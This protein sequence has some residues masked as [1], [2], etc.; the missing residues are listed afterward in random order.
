MSLR[1]GRRSSWSGVNEPVSTVAWPPSAAA[2]ASWS[3][4]LRQLSQPSAATCKMTSVSATRHLPGVYVR[5]VV[6]QVDHRLPHLLLA[7]TPYPLPRL[8][9]RLAAQLQQHRVGLLRPPV[10]SR[11]HVRMLP[12]AARL[13]GPG[14]ASGLWHRGVSLRNEGVGG[15]P[16]RMPIWARRCWL[17][18]CRPTEPPWAHAC[19]QGTHSAASPTAA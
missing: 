13:P 2:W 4:V 7:V 1:A 15:W 10:E 3:Q 9:R 5:E 12:T 16:R 6:E 8:P 18:P 17:G 14:G 19:S 11:R